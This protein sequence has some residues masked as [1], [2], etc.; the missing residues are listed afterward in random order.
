LAN[1]ADELHK[2]Q[3]SFQTGNSAKGSDKKKEKVKIPFKVDNW[4][5][6]LDFIA[7]EEEK[8]QAKIE[9][10]KIII[11]Q[12]EGEFDEYDGNFYSILSDHVHKPI[13]E[14]I[15]LDKIGNHQEKII[16]SLVRDAYMIEKEKNKKKEFN[17]VKDENQSNEAG[18]GN[19]RNAETKDEERSHDQDGSEEMKAHK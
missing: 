1:N 19:Q 17:R 3:S 9:L 4:R 2:Q 15:D 7:K 8:K 5:K 12:S 14:E 10:D 16:M 13:F 18:Q 6:L 11:E